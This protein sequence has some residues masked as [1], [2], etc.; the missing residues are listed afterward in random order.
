MRGL[1]AEDELKRVC[2][3]FKKLV[4]RFPDVTTHVFSDDHYF[5]I[6]PL[7]T[8]GPRWGD[9]ASDCGRN[10]SQEVSLHLRIDCLAKTACPSIELTPDTPQRTMLT[11]SSSDSVI[12]IRS[13][14]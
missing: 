13:P 8:A 2:Y 7:Q 14:P 5:T 10:R 6:D 1:R 3:V 4:E 11:K 12:P 9:R